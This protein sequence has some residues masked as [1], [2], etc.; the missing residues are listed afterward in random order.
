[1]AAFAVLTILFN[2][3]QN[4]AKDIG[5]NGQHVYILSFSSREYP[6]ADSLQTDFTADEAIL[7]TVL[8]NYLRSIEGIRA[9]SF[10]SQAIPYQNG[11]PLLTVKTNT[12]QVSALWYEADKNYQNVLG[13][14][15]V[16]GEWFDNYK[17]GD[18]LPLVAI[19]QTLKEKLFPEQSPI[20]KKVSLGNANELAVVA[21]VVENYKTINDFSDYSE[22]IITQLKSRQI[23]EEGVVLLKTNS[24]IN[25]IGNLKK[26]LSA[27]LTKKNV[28]ILPFFSERKT[29][30][31]FSLIPLFFF[32]IVA[33]YLI[34]NIIIGLVGLIWLDVSKRKQEIGLRRAIGATKGSIGRQIVLESI[35]ICG[36]GL[37]IGAVVVLPFPIVGAFN[38]NT[39]IFL[40]AIISSIVLILLL[41]IGCSAYPGFRIAN[42]SVVEALKEN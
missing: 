13:L 38:I 14:K 15:L 18:A 25:Q 23:T 12:N 24:D 27:L 4:Y 36:I 39:S 2:N 26:D 10:S 37:L 32:A 29:N 7:E 22:V 1:M 16:E 5:L 8:Q 41:A 11:H 20:G 9:F 35:L 21:A 28:K 42:L 6:T 34:I 3:L 19:N 33:S 17:L 40:L 30:N 31:T